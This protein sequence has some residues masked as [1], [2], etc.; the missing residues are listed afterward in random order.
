MK[1]EKDAM[2]VCDCCGQRIYVRNTLRIK[3]LG[4][5]REPGAVSS[6]QPYVTYVNHHPG[7]IRLARP[8]ETKRVFVFGKSCFGKRHLHRPR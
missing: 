2:T 7:W 3:Y 4:H 1:N 8:R 5:E 6:A